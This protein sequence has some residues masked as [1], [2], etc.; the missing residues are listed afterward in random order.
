MGEL[1]RVPIKDVGRISVDVNKFGHGMET[2]LSGMSAV[3]G[4]LGMAY[5][6]DDEAVQNDGAQA[7]EQESTPEKE[8]E[9]PEEQPAPEPPA[10]TI[11]YDDIIG[12]IVAKI[13]KNKDNNF[14]I[15]KLLTEQY[16]VAK[17]SELK[18]EQYEAFMM[19]LAQL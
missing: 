7:P 18:P 13:N 14:A 6:S 4:S 3:W 5:P 17:V 12:A 8:P 9:K 19:N 16:S 2:M 15:Q 1:I 10:S 11:S